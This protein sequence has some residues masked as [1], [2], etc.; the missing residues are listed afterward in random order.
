[1]GRGVLYT[2]IIIRRLLLIHHLLNQLFQV[3]H[4]LT[5][6]VVRDNV[7]IWCDR[8]NTFPILFVLTV[9][10]NISHGHLT[11]H[12]LSRLIIVLFLLQLLSNLHIQH[13]DHR[14]PLD[15]L[16]IIY[17]TTLLF[18]I[19]TH[20]NSLQGALGAAKGGF[21]IVPTAVVFFVFAIVVGNFGFLLLICLFVMFDRGVVQI[22]LAG[23][24]FTFRLSPITSTV[25]IFLII[26]KVDLLVLRLMAAAI[27]IVV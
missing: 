24:L 9:K 17:I 12:W 13:L 2:I 14:F 1:M 22:L 7:F 6:A 15:Q 27:L 16:Q 10:F 21:E 3:H 4:F 5:I 20:I 11:R 23:H 8:A 18:Q 26:E 19:K 25:S